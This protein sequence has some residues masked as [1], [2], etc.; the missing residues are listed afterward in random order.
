MRNCFC[1]LAYYGDA[2]VVKITCQKKFD[3]VIVLE[4][5]ND[6]YVKEIVLLRSFTE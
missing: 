6:G 2:S 3:S 4:S 1:K 5:L